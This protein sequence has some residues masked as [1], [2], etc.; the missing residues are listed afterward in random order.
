MI[1]SPPVNLSR[2]PKPSPPCTS[3]AVTSAPASPLATMGCTSGFNIYDIKKAVKVADA[4]YQR[5]NK[6]FDKIEKD[7]LY[8]VHDQTATNRTL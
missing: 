3:V 5:R 8:S 1:P 6:S 2:S 7:I 4:V